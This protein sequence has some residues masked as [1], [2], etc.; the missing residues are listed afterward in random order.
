M[1]KLY[2]DDDYASLRPADVFGWFAAIAN[3]PRGSGHEQRIAEA[4]IQFAADRNLEAERDSYNNVVIR[5]PGCGVAGDAGAPIIIQAHTDMVWAKTADS[6]F[7]FTAQPIKLVV[8]GNR[9]RSDRT[10]LGADNGI[11]VA[12]ALALLAATDLPHPPLEAVFTAGEE[13]RMMGATGLDISRLH[14][15]KLINIDS[16]DEGVFCASSAGG[17]NAELAYRPERIRLALLPDAADRQC[18]RIAVSGLRG[19]HSGVE[20]DKQ[21]GNAIQLLARMLNRIRN[22]HPILLA[23]FDGGVAHNVIPVSAEAVISIRHSDF[24][25][26]QAETAKWQETFRNELA[27]ADGMPDESGKAFLVRTTCD[28]IAPDQSPSRVLPAEATDTVIAVANLIPHGVA[29][30][31]LHITEQRLVETSSNFAQIH[32]MD[33]E[34]RFSASIR[35]STPSKCDWLA[36]RIAMLGQLAG[37]NILTGDGYPPWSYRQDSALRRVFQQAFAHVY[38]GNQAKVE[39]IHAGLECGIFASRFAELG[40]DLDIIS[41]GPDVRG[42]HTPD[43]WLDIGSTARTWELIKAALAIMAEN[44]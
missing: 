2:P 42:A 40:R 35:S 32:C 31:D 26:I 14:G 37:M 20:I 1:K 38:D 16:E 8:D 44:R 30:M 43:E 17:L 29:A 5:K 7:D 22:N 25:A 15:D 4:L 3:I 36:Q 24:D 23:D 28:R 12:Y 11:G 6:D 33:G 21:G 10:T 27:A 34:I 39:G 9:L 41:I 13:T 19:G 18:V